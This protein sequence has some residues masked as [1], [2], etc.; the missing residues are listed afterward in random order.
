MNALRKLVVIGGGITGLSAAFYALKQAD[1]EG[2]PISVTII[3]QSDRLGGKIQTLRKEGCVI[4]KGPDSFLAR[5]LPMIDLA[6]DLGMES[7][8]VA[9]N[10]HA[11]KTY[12]LRRGKLYRMPPGLVLGIP[13]ELGPFAKTGLISPWGKLRAAMDLFIKPRPSDEDE[14]VGAFL[15]RRLGREVT[16]HI[17]EPLLAGIYAGD[18]QALSLQA[19]FPQFAQVERKH[20]G[21]IRGMKASRQAGQS[22]PGLP[23]VAKGTMFLTFRNGLTSLVER[24]E[25]TLQ[26]RAELRLGIGAEGLE[27]REDGTYLVRLSDG[28]SLLA[29]AVIVTTP[30]YHAASFLEEHIDASSLK[31]IRHVSVANVVSVFDRKQVK[32][33]FDGTGF[34]ISRREG[35]AITACTWT[36]VKWPH[37]SRGDKLIIRCYIGRA[38]DEERVDW[39]DEALK[40]TVRSELRELLDID[41]DPEFVE[42]T[43]LRHSMPQYPVGH[44]QAIRS[45]RDEVGRALPGVF[46]AGQPYEGVGMPDCVR[47]GRDAAEAAVSAMQAM[48]TETGAPAEDAATGTAG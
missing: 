33:Q 32:N 7:E 48:S 14:S 36:S 19:T 45:L 23:D 30:S 44:V 39:P 5:K 10:P 24:L 46:L 11:K 16:E 15:D 4:E 2:Q 13:T 26:E 22:V 25:E 41:I 29:D 18:L 8:L 3:E 40:R 1:E 28:S 6:R 12:I 34:V 37:T 31:A 9:T 38:G 35:R 20:G 43:R 47:S 42:I 17:A 27:K 21:L